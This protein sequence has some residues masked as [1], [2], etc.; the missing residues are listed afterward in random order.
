MAI[1]SFLETKAYNSLMEVQ[2]VQFAGGMW[3]AVVHIPAQFVYKPMDN[4]NHEFGN[5][6]SL[7]SYVVI[8]IK[9]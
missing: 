1:F 3:T 8:E 9:K 6:K 7:C 4:M 2:T 5:V